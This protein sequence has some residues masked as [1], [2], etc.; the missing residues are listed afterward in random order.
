VTNSVGNVQSNSALLT[1]IVVTP[2]SIIGATVVNGLSLQTY[3]VNQT[4]GST[5]AFSVVNG[6]QVS[7]SAN[8][9]TVQWGSTGTGQII[10]TETSSMGCVSDPSILNIQILG[11]PTITL[12]PQP[13]TICKNA[14]TS[15]TVAA[16]GSSPFYYTW[17]KDGNQLP[18][19]NQ[20]TYYVFNAQP[21][22]AGNYYCM[23]NNTNGSVQS[24]NA[25]LSVV[26]VVPPTIWGSA[27]VPEWS[28]QTYSVTQTAGS[29]YAFSIAG[30]NILSTTANSVTVQWGS[31]GYG[32]IICIETNSIGCVSDQ[33]IF[34]IAIGSVGI[35]EQIADQIA[36]YPNPTSGEINVSSGNNIQTIIIYNSLGA[37]ICEKNVENHQFSFEL[38]EFGR[39][40]YF[41][42]V[43]RG[44]DL[45]NRKI[46]VK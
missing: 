2:P 17:Y 42:S 3:S 25:A 33:S 36:I 19:G 46:V 9:I 8:S 24:N 23:V 39:G 7:V 30:G 13:Q 14:N 15:F 16:S 5:Y 29:S 26:V 44:N 28:L 10:C 21:A 6:N 11:S 32:Q 22:D 20:P 43:K 40:V 27:L 18:N 1:V 34:I 35:K 12:Q 41:I 38:S 31:M 45:I 37:K 4:S